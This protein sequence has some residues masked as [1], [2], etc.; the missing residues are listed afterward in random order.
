MGGT[1]NWGNETAALAIDGSL[2]PLGWYMELWSAGSGGVVEWTPTGTGNDTIVDTGSVNADNGYFYTAST[3][4]GGFTGYAILWNNSDKA[5]ATHYALLG[6]GDTDAVIASLPNPGDTADFT[7]N[8]SAAGLSP[9]GDWLP[10]PEP[11][12]MAMVFIGVATLIGRR[13]ARNRG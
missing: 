12:S 4:A 10:V 1:I 6:I 13:M 2:A 5:L 7:M 11:S 9:S 3:S 8:G